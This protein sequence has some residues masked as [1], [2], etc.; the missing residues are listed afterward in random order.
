[1]LKRTDIALLIKRD[2]QMSAVTGLHEVG[3]SFMPF[4]DVWR[5]QETMV[6]KAKGVEVFPG[7]LDLDI[8]I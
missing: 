7:R 8:L 4:F 6:Y 5:K 3:K 2:P 1:M